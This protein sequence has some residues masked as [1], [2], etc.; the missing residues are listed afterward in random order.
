MSISKRPRIDPFGFGNPSTR[1]LAATGAPLATCKADECYW[2][3]AKF[4]GAG[5]PGS[6]LALKPVLPC[7][8]RGRQEAKDPA[9]AVP[10]QRDGIHT[11]ETEQPDH[12]QS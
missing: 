3:N 5:E 4:R 9:R 10:S 12:M 6:R 11:L 7:V 8:D 2:T 1:T